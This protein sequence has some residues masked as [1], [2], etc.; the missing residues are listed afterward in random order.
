MRCVQ[1]LH[2][3]SV[4]CDTCGEK[5][6]MMFGAHTHARTRTHTH[7]HTHTVH[8]HTTHTLTHTLACSPC[9]CIKINAVFPCSADRGVPREVTNKEK[10]MDGEGEYLQLTER[11]VSIQ[12]TK[13]SEVVI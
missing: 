11:L 7:T 9:V 4:I 2:Y 10:R 13:P 1:V 5:G 12:H 8:T 3:D 6:V